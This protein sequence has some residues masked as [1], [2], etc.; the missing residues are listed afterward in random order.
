MTRSSFKSTNLI[1]K[2]CTAGKLHARDGYS[3]FSESQRDKMQQLMHA[4][5][6]LKENRQTDSEVQ[7]VSTKV[8]TAPKVASSASPQQTKQ[9]VPNCSKNFEDCLKK[10]QQKHKSCDSVGPSRWPFSSSS[11]K[12]I[13]FNAKKVMLKMSA[14]GH[15]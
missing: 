3:S 14:N 10:Q 7:A 11:V 1:T 2:K 12:M 13:G 6:W 9:T 8:Q 15:K 5:L 4:T